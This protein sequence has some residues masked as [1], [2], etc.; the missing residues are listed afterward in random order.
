MRNRLLRRITVGVLIVVLT[1]SAALLAG[2]GE[3]SGGGGSS[4]KTGSAMNSAAKYLV[5]N[6]EV[7][8]FDSMGGGWVPFALKMSGTDA[9]DDNYYNA[10]YDSIRVAVKNIGA[11]LSEDR[12]T[13]NERVSMNLKAI[14]KDPTSVEGADLMEAVDDYDLITRQGLN[15]E[16]YALISSDYTGCTLKNEGKY[17]DD[18]IESQS[19]EGAFGM[20]SAHPDSDMTAMALQA[21]SIYD[22]RIEGN[23]KSDPRVE[24]AIDKAIEWLQGQQ[25]DDGSFGNSES[26]AQVIIAMNCLG[27][28]PE[29]DEL[30]KGDNNLCDG[31]MTFYTGKGFS[32]EAGDEDDIMATEQSL[33]ALDAIMLGK[34][35]KRIFK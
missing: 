12:P 19:P 35:G 9:A 33:L 25:Q 11:L 14:G 10:Y 29:G 26:T 30:M 27:R 1:M 13:A 34:E 24:G 18:L 3:S 5:E 17:L 28:D 2:C 20:D 21:L 6:V 16:I 4:S 32:H 15:A 31:L 22:S 23:E 7:D 8:S